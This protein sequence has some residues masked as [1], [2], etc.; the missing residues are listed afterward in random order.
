MVAIEVDYIYK[1][2]VSP[3]GAFQLFFLR[4]IIIDLGRPAAPVPELGHRFV[5]GTF[6]GVRDTRMRARECHL[7]LAMLMVRLA[8]MVGI[9]PLF[10]RYSGGRYPCGCRTKDHETMISSHC[11]CD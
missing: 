9:C 11:L 6:P 1:S 7:V 3:Q 8:F 4:E 2:G 5:W 10:A